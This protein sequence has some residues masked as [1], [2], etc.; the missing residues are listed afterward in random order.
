MF[1]GV[2]VSASSF[3]EVVRSVYIAL[4]NRV[5][6]ICGLKT[7]RPAPSD[8]SGPQQIL[9]RKTKAQI[10]T[11]RIS[12]YATTMPCLSILTLFQAS[13][14][15]LTVLLALPLASSAAGSAVFFYAVCFN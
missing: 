5:H 9:Y 13:L 2:R 12:T 7:T 14:F 10:R 15:F 3:F 1:T 11:D 6:L 8:R 4:P